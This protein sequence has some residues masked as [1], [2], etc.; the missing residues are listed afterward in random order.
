MCANLFRPRRAATRPLPI[1]QP[2]SFLY[3][4]KMG[5]LGTGLPFALGAK[6]A[7]PERPVCCITGDGALGFCI[8]ERITAQRAD[9]PLIVV[10]A[11]DDAWG[12]E[13]TAFSARGF[14]PVQQADMSIPGVRSDLMA[15]A[16]GCHGEY[17]ADAAALLPALKR[18]AAAGVPAL[19]HVCVDA[20]V[21]MN[22]IGWKEFRYARSL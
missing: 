16:M 4:V 5:Y 11:V 7:A 14:G 8:T 19:I 2:D 20:E 10:A 12:M 1:L 13:R 22:P 15:Q 9:V 21:N 17:V 18:A 3:S 6:L